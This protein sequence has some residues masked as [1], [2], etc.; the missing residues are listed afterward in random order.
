MLTGLERTADG[1]RF[2]AE[3][4]AYLDVHGQRAD[5]W[6]LCARF[7]IEDPVEGTAVVGEE[8]TVSI[9]IEADKAP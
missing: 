7:W 8:V 5:R 4:T 9:D 3:L 6:G 2:L 1:R